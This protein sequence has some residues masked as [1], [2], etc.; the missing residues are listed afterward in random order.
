MKAPLLPLLLALPALAGEPPAEDRAAILAMAGT[1]SVTFHFEETTAI[2]E[3]YTLRSKPYDEDATEVI[4]V[5]EDTPARITLQ[6]LLV[7]PDRKQGGT[8]VIKHWA[9]VWTWEDRQLL[10]YMG[11]DGDHLWRKVELS[12]EQ[13]AGTWSQLVTQVD[14][15]PRYEGYGRWTHQRGESS[16]ESAPTRR[17]LPRREYS[18]RDDYDYLLVTNRHTLTPGGWI[19]LQD[20]RKVVDR[21]GEPAR[22]LCLESGLNTYTRSESPD[23]HAALDW[24]K[25]HG[26][27]WNGVR[28]FWIESGEAAPSR[29]TYTTFTND[30]PLSKLIGRLEKQPPAPAEVAAALRPYV[31]A[32]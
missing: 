8:R 31:V 32:Q 28:E 24:W 9:Q 19:H 29:F 6:N 18:K 11:E 23:A 3:G 2:A 16:W 1:H 21:D 20:N 4:V 14:D 30:E 7:V 10:D 5:V 25:E 13:A 22:V 15:T 17:P 12:P 27:F 26:A